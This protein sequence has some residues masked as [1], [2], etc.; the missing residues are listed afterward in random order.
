MKLR[1]VVPVNAFFPSFFK[2]FS[3][4]NPSMR[5]QNGKRRDESKKN[6]KMR[7]KGFPL[8]LKCDKLTTVS[9]CCFVEGENLLL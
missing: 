9:C 7:E 5:M 3:S 4:D 1:Q 6:N 2:N 8:L